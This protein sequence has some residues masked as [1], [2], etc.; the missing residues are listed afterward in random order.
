[1]E[2][3]QAHIDQMIFAAAQALAPEVA[4]H[5]RRNMRSSAPF[6]VPPKPVVLDA[7]LAMRGPQAVLDLAGYFPKKALGSP[8]LF[9][10]LNSPNPEALVNKLTCYDRYFHP[11]RS[12]E[13]CAAGEHFI[14]AQNTCRDS[15]AS[16]E[17]ELFVCGVLR[18]LLSMIGCSGLQIEWKTVSSERLRLLLAQ[19]GITAGEN[20]PFTRWC[21]RWKSFERP[22]EIPGLNEFI[23]E[24][25]PV[26]RKESTY[27]R[28][29]RTQLMADLT[30]RPGIKQIAS[31]IGI[32]VRT[33]QREL[34]QEGTTFMRVYDQLRVETA[35][36]LLRKQELSLTDISYLSGFSDNAHLTRVLKK[37]LNVT[38][39]EFQ[40]ALIT[41]N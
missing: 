30:H 11:N 12:I 33:L 26:N 29:V 35:Q 14:E 19:I 17:D 41:G 32:S 28:L 20:A 3:S 23:A 38:P 39:A 7:L 6:S 27:T 37:S 4:E 21:I 13:L 2:P 31:K 1:M 9:L 10:M 5:S 34:A 25:V 16:A 24:I 8:L 36:Y 15:K 22:L 18:A 40:K